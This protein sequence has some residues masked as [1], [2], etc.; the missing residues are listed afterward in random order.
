MNVN[1][2]VHRGYHMYLSESYTIRAYETGPDGYARLSTMCNLLQEAASRHA[3]LLD[4]GYESMKRRELFWVLSRLS[5]RVDRY[6]QLNESLI[7]RTWPKGLN[8]P[9]ALRDFRFTF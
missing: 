7:V 8:G 2:Y 1:R 5:V 6:P 4:F 3:E 9:F